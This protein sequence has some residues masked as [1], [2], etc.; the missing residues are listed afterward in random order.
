MSKKIMQQAAP[1]QPYIDGVADDNPVGNYRND[2]ALLSAIISASDDAILS[3]TLD[4]I[5]TSWNAGAERMFGYASKEIIG[6]HKTVLFPVDRLHEEEAILDKIRRGI[7]IEHFET[8]RLRKDGTQIFVSVTI[9]PVR[10]SRGKVIGASTIARDITASKYEKEQLKL[11]ST[12]AEES[13]S[14][15]VIMD[16]QQRIIYVNHSFERITG[17]S[18]D[19][20]QGFRLEQILKSS[21][22]DVESRVKIR[23]AIS[24]TK[25]VSAEIMNY[26]K[27]GSQFWIEINISPVIDT[28]DKLSH[29]VAIVNDI[30]SRRKSESLLESS[31]RKLEAV[32]ENSP[33]SMNLLDI[34]GRLLFSNQN[35]KI[36]LEADDLSKILGMDWL[37]I[38]KGEAEPLALIAVREAL[39]GRI[40][41]FQGFCSS[42]KELP[43]WWDVIVSPILDND[44]SVIQILCV[45]R[46]ITENHVLNEQL[47]ERVVQIERQNTVLESLAT[48][49]GLTGLKNHRA[50]QERLHEEFSHA[51]RCGSPLSVIMIDVDKFKVYNDTYGH[52][53]GDLILRT[54]A[55]VLRSTT[56]GCDILARYGGEEFAVLLPNVAQWESKIVAERFRSAIEKTSWPASSI[57]ISLGVDTLDANTVNANSL[58]T[59]ADTALYRSKNRG[60]NCSTHAADAAAIESLDMA[61]AKWYDDI[62]Q[63]HH[64][65]EPEFIE[66]SPEEVREML[67]QAYE[68]TVLSWSQILIHKEKESELHIK[69]VTDLL[70]KMMLHIGYNEEQLMFA[71]WGGLLHDIGKIA[72]PDKILHK[73]SPLTDEEW[74]IM[75]QH[76]SVAHELISPIRFL[77]PAVDIPYCHHE[78]WDGTGYPRGLKG[79]EIPELAR[80]FA[81]LD[82]YDALSNDRPNRSAWPQHQVI[83]YIQQQSGSHFEPRAVDAFLSMIK[84][85][86]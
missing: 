11:L 5:I 34:Y 62:L 17:Y 56:R 78:K 20:F 1:L 21:N 8:V 42:I 83:D 55:D 44:G 63:K 52:P 46:N 10:D 35:G 45:S 31:R 37:S 23:T 16:L 81:V 58:L 67:Y 2:H 73:S 70:M 84:K 33:D 50:L 79:E 59:A 66:S 38:W 32:L 86:D 19:E 68:T 41:R 54:V 24:E 80:L 72:I 28:K 15:I 6:Q 75:R 74:T 7:P 22:I 36:L 14:G 65:I 53:A 26:H 85:E 39:E 48:T 12:V 51:R 43:K 71:R 30:T 4:G 18:L 61:A 76:T 13:T 82:V 9:S 69:R 77:G 40:G 64:S 60:R 57:T 29:Y 47:H 49:D 3:K 27:N 25:P